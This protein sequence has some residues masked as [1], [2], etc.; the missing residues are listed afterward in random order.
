VYIS[1]VLD[2]YSIIKNEA[3]VDWYKN[4]D[5]KRKMKNSVDDYLYDVVKGKKGINIDSTH[6]KVIID[7]VM[8]LAEN[9]F[10]LFL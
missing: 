4:M 6:I 10:D 9:N 3:I 2:I 1:V 7:N 8:Q 5:V